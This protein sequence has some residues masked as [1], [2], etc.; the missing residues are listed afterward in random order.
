[1]LRKKHRPAEWEVAQCDGCGRDLRQ[2]DGGGIENVNHGTLK[3]NFGWPSPLDDY[4]EG[5]EY[6]LC[7][8]CWVKALRRFDLPVAVES[9]GDRYMPD[10]RILDR[11]RKDTRRKW[12][13]EA[14]LAKARKLG[15]KR[16]E[17]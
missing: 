9:N 12:D 11:D 4:P 17:A 10:G 2:D 15:P 8:T 16:S 14:E 13:V 1:M 5:P 3:A 7:E 6:H